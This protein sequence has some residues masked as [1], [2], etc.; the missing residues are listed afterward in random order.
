MRT[1]RY[2]GEMKL[3]KRTFSEVMSRLREV[4]NVCERWIQ[5][6]ADLSG[7]YW[8]TLDTH[9]WVGDQHKDDLMKNMA[10]RLVV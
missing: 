1:H 5:T 9:A 4:T 7:T 3:W 8:P 2:L 6:M 10:K